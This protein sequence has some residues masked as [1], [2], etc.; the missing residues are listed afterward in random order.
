[1]VSL[2]KQIEDLR[3]TK[4]W[5]TAEEI[6]DV[7]DS[8]SEF[9]EWLKEIVSKQEKLAKHED[10]MLKED[11]VFNKVKKIAN[12]YQKISKKKKPRPP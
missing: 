1:M 3:D 2:E 12:L 5:I 7:T 9:R 6:K 8:I 10:P 4:S 11:E